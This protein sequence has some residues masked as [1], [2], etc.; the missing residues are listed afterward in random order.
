MLTD[1]LEMGI[2]KGQ[3]TTCKTE[4]AKGYSAK[5]IPFGAQYFV[6]SRIDSPG[7]L[8]RW[9]WKPKYKFTLT[10]E[11]SASWPGTT[12]TGPTAREDERYGE[13]Q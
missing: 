12:G 5:V 4:I 8:E 11:E 13:T 2:E 9:S 10:T 1:S 6:K 3:E 7:P